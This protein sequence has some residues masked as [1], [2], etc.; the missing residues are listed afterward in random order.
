MGSTV[1]WLVD[2][3]F[4]VNSKHIM[5]VHVPQEWTNSTITVASFPGFP[6]SFPSLAVLRFSR[7]ANDGK[8]EGK[9]GNEARQTVLSH[10]DHTRGSLG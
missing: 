8:L 7:T 1:S 4:S 9:P 10:L 6:S 3:T 2:Y 5:Y